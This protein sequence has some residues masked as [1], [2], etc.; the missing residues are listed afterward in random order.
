MSVVWKAEGVSDELEC[1]AEE[2][3]KESIK[4]VAWFL[5]V[6]CTKL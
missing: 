2:I 4:D 5:L 1:L 3:S 6:T